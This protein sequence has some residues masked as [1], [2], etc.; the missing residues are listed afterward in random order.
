MHAVRRS[1]LCGVCFPRGWRPLSPR[2][3]YASRFRLVR[4]LCR[5]RGSPDVAAPIAVTT[6]P[7][8]RWLLSLAGGVFLAG[9]IAFGGWLGVTSTVEPASLLVNSTISAAFVA[10]AKEASTTTTVITVLSSDPRF[11][12]AVDAS[13]GSSSPISPVDLE[14][15]KVEADEAQ[16]TAEHLEG[17]AAPL[18]AF[19]TAS[20]GLWK[21]APLGPVAC[22][23]VLQRFESIA[24]PNELMAL[25][26]GL[27][28]GPAR[29]VLTSFVTI[30]ARVA[31]ECGSVESNVSDMAWHW[32]LGYRRLVELGVH[33]P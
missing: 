6:I 19:M 3:A 28:D 12:A 31:S 22:D 9:A 5:H 15:P 16:L 20:E 17:E 2:A 10:T 25:A 27:S 23:A 24:P 8:R 21:E 30:A 18:T 1:N 11:R 32:A 26:W 4:A 29:D 7:E 13:S 14:F 33:L